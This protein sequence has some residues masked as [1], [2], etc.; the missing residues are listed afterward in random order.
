MSSLGGEGDC[1][2]ARD[3]LHLGKKSEPKTVVTE[4]GDG[5]GAKGPLAR[6]AFRSALNSS[7]P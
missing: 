2:E 1:D 6:F 5:D 7:K 4:A 3:R